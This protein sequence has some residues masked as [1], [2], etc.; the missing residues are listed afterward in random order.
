MGAK[1]ST[2]SAEESFLQ[3]CDCIRYNADLIGT[4]D[5]EKNPVYFVRLRPWKQDKR[6]PIMFCGYGPDLVTAMREAIADYK[7]GEERPLDYAYRP[8]VTAGPTVTAPTF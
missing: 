1:V 4:L 5:G 7:D 6:S 3:W 8:W 2:Q